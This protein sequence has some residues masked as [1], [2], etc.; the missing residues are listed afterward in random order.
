ME[1]LGFGISIVVIAGIGI[2]VWAASMSM[3][4]ARITEYVRQRGGR[5]VSISWAP[6][7]RG[8]FGEKND[9]IYEVVYH[10]SAGNQHWATCKTS[11]FS[12]V[13]WTEDRTAYQ[14][15][16]WYDGLPQ[17]NEPGDPVIRHI[18]NPEKP[19]EPEAKAPGLAEPAG[20]LVDPVDDEIARLRQRLAELERQKQQQ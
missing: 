20:S 12:G 6:F 14:K 2:L 11:L 1:G 4:K 17:R 9:R 19:A 5:V 13:Y 18:P 8:W 3:D 7:G 16:G 15:P 10:D